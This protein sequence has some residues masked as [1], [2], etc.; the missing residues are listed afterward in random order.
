MEFSISEAKTRFSKLI[1]LLIDEKEERIIIT[2]YGKP[3][4]IIS[5]YIEENHKRI[6][7]LKKAKGNFDIS[8]EDFNS[9]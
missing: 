7:L 8:L 1:Q 6:G 3:I 5:P 2:K 4:V 9:I